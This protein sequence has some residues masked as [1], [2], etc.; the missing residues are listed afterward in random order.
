MAGVDRNRHLTA[1]RVPERVVRAADVVK[2]EAEARER[3]DDLF[4]RDPR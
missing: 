2:R 3:R 4:A 1:S